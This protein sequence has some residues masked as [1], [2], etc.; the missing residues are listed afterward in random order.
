MTPRARECSGRT[1]REA[2]V[3]SQLPFHKMILNLKLKFKRRTGRIW[4][5]NLIQG[6]EGLLEILSPHEELF[7][8]T[9]HGVARVHVSAHPFVQTTL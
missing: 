9:G 2:R 7:A 4:L 6:C 8:P 1:H 3:L 5:P